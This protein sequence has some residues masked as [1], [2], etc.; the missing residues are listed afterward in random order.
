MQ[1]VMREQTRRYN[2]LRVAYQSLSR[3]LEG[4]G[5]TKRTVG[6]K[7]SDGRLRQTKFDLR[8]RKVDLRDPTVRAGDTPEAHVNNRPCGG[9]GLLIRSIGAQ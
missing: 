7:G 5:E 1:A 2:D 3:R 6:G 9:A 8:K 4:K